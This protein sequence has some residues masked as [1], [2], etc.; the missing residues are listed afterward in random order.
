MLYGVFLWYNMYFVPYV[1]IWCNSPLKYWNAWTHY[2]C[3]KIISY[4]YI[5]LGKWCRVKDKVILSY[6]PSHSKPVT[7]EVVGH[8]CFHS[9]HAYSTTLWKDVKFLKFWN[10]TLPVC[11]TSKTLLSRKTNMLPDEKEIQQ[12]CFHSFENLLVPY[13]LEVLH[14]LFPCRKKLLKRPHFSSI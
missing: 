10:S 11:F 7:R 12:S 9:T 1:Y 4:L 3:N 14:V 5:N 2:C 8:L 13:W 6:E